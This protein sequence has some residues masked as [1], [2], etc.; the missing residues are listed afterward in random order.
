ME[1]KLSSYYRQRFSGDRTF[2]ARITDTIFFVVVIALIGYRYFARQSIAWYIA[3]LLGF[4]LGIL[5]L[6]A[7][8]IINSMR[9]ERFV[10]KE[11]RQI[12]KE[13][14]LSR[15]SVMSESDYSKIVESIVKVEN[16]NRFK[17]LILSFQNIDEICADEIAKAYRQAISNKYEKVY[18]FSCSKLSAKA[19]DFIDSIKNVEFVI[20]TQDQLFDYTKRLFP[21]SDDEIDE[22]IIKRENKKRE[23]R[24]SRYKSAFSKSRLTPYFVFGAFLLIAS[25]FVRFSLYYRLLAGMCFGMAFTVAMLERRR[26]E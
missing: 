24:K 25:Y 4:A 12:E 6:V 14:A 8:R 23:E 15:L 13:I 9:F 11:R 7:Y 18:V 19:S 20:Y 21:I 10:E 1:K 16:I 2:F 5:V 26:D 17:C 3:I 22:T